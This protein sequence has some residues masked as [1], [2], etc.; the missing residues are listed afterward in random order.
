MSSPGAYSLCSANS[1]D[2]AGVRVPGAARRTP[3]R[4]SRAPARSSI[5]GARYPGSSASAGMARPLLGR[6]DGL[7]SAA[8][9]E[10]CA[11]RPSASAWK[12]RIKR[13][14]STGAASAQTSSMDG[15]EPAIEMAR[16]LAPASGTARPAAPRPRRHFSMNSGASGSA[17]RVA[18]RARPRTSPRAATPAREAPDPAAGGSVRRQHLAQRRAM[19]R[20]H[21]G[22]R[23]APPLC[24]RVVDVD[25]E[26]EAIELRLGE[27]IGALLLDR[28]LGREHQERQRQRVRR[29]RR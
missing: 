24:R 23:S 7:R 27:G 22:G 17:G 8:I 11:P 25:L 10:L 28:V 26:H 13:W 6:R 1:I 4:R 21:A 18:R 5:R 14:T 16:A 15:G 9:D 2:A 19:A 20:R 12:L 3:P 29:R